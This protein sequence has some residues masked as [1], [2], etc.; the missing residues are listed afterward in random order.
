[1]NCPKCNADIS[2]TFEP[3]DPSCGISAAVFANGNPFSGDVPP[4]SPAMKQISNRRNN[5]DGFL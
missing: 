1:M 3:D 5:H 4:P 2:D